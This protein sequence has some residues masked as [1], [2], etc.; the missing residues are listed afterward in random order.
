MIG[1]SYVSGSRDVIQYT[2][3]SETTANTPIYVAGIGVL[4]PVASKAA[5]VKGSYNRKGAYRFIVAN[6]VAVTVGA[7]V[8][9]DSAANKIQLTAPSSGF[10]LG[11]ALEAGTGNAGGTVAVEVDVNEF[12]VELGNFTGIDISCG[13]VAATGKITS[14]GGQVVGKQS[15]FDGADTAPTLTAAQVLGG[16]IIGTPTAGRTYT[17]PAADA[18]LALVPGA[19]VGSC[20][21]FSV[22]NLAASSNAITVAASESITNGGIAGHLV[23]AA[24]SSKRF[25]IVF[26]NVT[27]D[28]EAA[29]IYSA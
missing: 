1:A 3:S 12:G 20:V 27:A 9:F 7:K 25:K 4:V 6:S 17:L 28:S 5:N 14:A 15:V 23:V 8:Y 11:T 22:T 18:L 24:A 26:T 2:Y 13:A 10:L 29:V 16:V 21:E 19:V